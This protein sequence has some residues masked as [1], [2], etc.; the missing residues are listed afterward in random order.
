[1]T[2]C[3]H[4]APEERPSFATLLERLDYCLQDP[5]VMSAPLPVFSRPPSHE[6][7]PTV[8]RPNN[9]EDSCLEVKD[10]TPNLIV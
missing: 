2:Q 9:T 6:R 8:M 1:M 3:W 4:P 10:L 7:D 5:N